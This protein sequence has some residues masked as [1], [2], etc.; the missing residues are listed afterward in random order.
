MSK[1]KKIEIV[2]SMDFADVN[3]GEI[4]TFNVIKQQE[5][6]SNF[7]KIWVALIFSAIEE[8]GSRKMDVLTWLI[9]N[10]DRGNNTILKTVAEIA[11][12]TKIDRGTI[13]ATLK[14]LVKHNLAKRKPGIIWLSPAAIFRGGH[15]KRMNVLIQFNSIPSPEVTEPIYS[16]PKQLKAASAEVKDL[17]VKKKKVKIKAAKTK[18]G[19]KK[20]E[21]PNEHDDRERENLG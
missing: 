5:Q 8:F 15:G 13:N 21:I 14:I 16:K 12:K 17:E 6:D 11:K 18:A 7:D 3:T 4:S 19:A 10:R 2:G 20:N 1:S 9:E